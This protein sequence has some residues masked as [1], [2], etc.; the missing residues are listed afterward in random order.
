MALGE[1]KISVDGK[2][3][4]NRGIWSSEV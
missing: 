2:I 1:F 3:R 4:V